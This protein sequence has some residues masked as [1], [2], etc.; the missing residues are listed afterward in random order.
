[1]QKGISGCKFLNI[2]LDLLIT[3]TPNQSSSVWTVSYDS[4]FG[5]RVLMYRENRGNP[6]YSHMNVFIVS[7]ENYTFLES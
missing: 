3:H 6:G 2:G 5:K 7:M 4:V 1:M